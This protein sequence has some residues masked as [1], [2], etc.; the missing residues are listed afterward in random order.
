MSKKWIRIENLQVERI[1]TAA[2]GSPTIGGQSAGEQAYLDGVTAG[3]VSVSKAVVVDANKDIGDFRNVDMVNL[4]AG[5]SGTAGTVDIFPTTASKGKFILSCTD[6][7]GA[8]NV[9]LKPAA[10]AQ[11]SVISIPDPGAATANVLLTSAANDQAVVA[12]TA[13]ELDKLAA[14]TAGTVAASKAV[15]VDSNKDVASFRDV[16]VRYTKNTG[17]VGTANTGVTAAEYGDGFMHHTVLTI[18][19]GDALT[20]GDAAALGA[21]YKIYDLPTGQVVLH[22]ASFKAV[23][24]TADDV[25]TQ[26]D[27]PDVGLGTTVASGVVSVLSGTAAFENILTGQTATDCNGTAINAVVGT[28]LV[29]ADGDSHSVY[30]NVADTWADSTVQT[31]DLAGE[32][33]LVWSFMGDPA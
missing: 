2:G 12:A 27:T 16:T 21:G 17:N 30:L 14:V 4:D 11:A 13:A 33:H 31:V 3:T 24:L 28:Q 10:M 6:Q 23:T 18:S 19:Q 15:V 5:A 9:T 25:A 1:E 32:V 7:D 8:T 26:S 22:S 20:V 29:V